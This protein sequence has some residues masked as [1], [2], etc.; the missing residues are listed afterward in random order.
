[1]FVQ[2]DQLT[3]TLKAIGELDDHDVAFVTTDDAKKYLKILNDKQKSEGKPYRPYLD[4]LK[5]VHPDLLKLLENMLQLNPY[6]RW[7]PA[8][9]L[10]LPIFDNV[11]RVKLERPA[12]VKMCL[13]VDEDGAYDFK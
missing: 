4:T 12:P 6:Q 8:E 1:M 3:L 2:T 11:R 7:S 5:G 9:C 10:S 13:E